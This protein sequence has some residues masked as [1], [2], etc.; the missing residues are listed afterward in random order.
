M[1]LW[2][3]SR[4]SVQFL[5][6]LVFFG[7]VAYAIVPFS[8]TER[9]A[10]VPP[11]L[12]MDATQTTFLVAIGIDKLLTD[13]ASYYDTA[14]LYPD[15]TQLRSLEPLLGFALVGLPLRTLLHLGD[16]DLYEVLRWLVIFTSLTY[17]W[18]LFKATGVGSALSVAGAVACLSQPSLLNSIERLH[19]ICIPLLLPVLF[20]GLMVW[21][22]QPPRFGHRLGLFVW[23]A[24]YPLCGM[25]N[26]TVCVIAG[27]LML[28]WLWMMISG[29][30]RHRRLGAL[31]VPIVAAIVVDVVL[32]SPW[33]FDRGDLRVYGSPE[34]LSI[35]NW[36]PTPVPLRTGQ[37]AAS[38]EARVGFSILAAMAALLGTL[39]LSRR[40]A[41]PR[42]GMPSKASARVSGLHLWT[43]PLL[44]IIVTVLASYGITRAT[45]TWPGV[46]F[47]VGCAAALAAYWR[48]QMQL[49]AAR[50]VQGLAPHLIVIGAG[51][52]VFLALVSFGPAYESNRHFLANGLTRVLIEA[53][54]PLRFIREFNRIWIFAMLF[55]SVAV[56]VRLGLELQ[57]WRPQFG[58]IAAAVLL[59]AAFT[60][61][62]RRPLEASAPIEAPQDFVK[63]VAQSHG[64]GA[65]YVHPY[66]EWN[67]RSGVMMMDIARQLRRPIVNGYLG[68]S[69]PWFTYATN[70][71]RK[72]P[73]PEAL[74]LLK[75]WKVETVV[76]LEGD[77]K[78]LNLEAGE[79]VLGQHDVAIWDLPPASYQLHPSGE[80]ALSAEA[81]ERLEAKWTW[82]DRRAGT[83]RA[84]VPVG[85]SVGAVEISFAQT[86]VPS[87]PAT[88]DV[89]GFD[90]SGRIRV[91][92]GFSGEWLHALAADA[93]V[94]RKTPVATIKL[95][96][97][98]TGDLEVEC[99]DIVN[100]SIS[101][102]VLVGRR[103]TEGRRAVR[104]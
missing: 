78:V 36:W 12:E 70:V 32:L 43:V 2:R 71:L 98:V 63:L 86:A 6:V 16:V 80:T 59:A 90:G 100:P 17:C 31:A 60:T 35:K 65:I 42:T 1:S 4:A 88:V 83:L 87:V 77:L 62:S 93:L 46:L 73:D 97:S 82:L 29:L 92:Q 89:F 61:I 15:R 45:A 48:V 102:V 47:D 69:P 49:P 54:P 99:R 26:A 13:P 19:I 56:I 10:L 50:D 28:P 23:V 5:L 81:H 101:R 95:Q 96:Q 41:L 34:F 27:V 20:H 76:S 75:K 84:T 11:G 9:V 18:L 40:L 79:R 94:H 103:F 7:L 91:N 8:A 24:L 14:I 72:F 39:T 104:H 55:W 58:T 30:W 38:L 25:I 57:R 53:V 37:L 44:V 67:T 66:M 22:D 74:W 51:L 3:R 21:I 68:V 85:F 33:L 64:K 52:G